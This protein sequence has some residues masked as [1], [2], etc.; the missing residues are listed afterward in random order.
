MLN[1][2]LFLFNFIDFS[3]Q[4]RE[5]FRVVNKYYLHKCLLLKISANIIIVIAATTITNLQ[6]KILAVSKPAPKAIADEQ[7]HL[8]L[9]ISITL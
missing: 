6:E 9:H 5:E 2:L 8:L 4:K 3:K 1:R 7:A